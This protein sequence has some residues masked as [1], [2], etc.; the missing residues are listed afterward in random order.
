MIANYLGILKQRNCNKTDGKKTIKQN[1]ADRKSI[2]P[3]NYGAFAGLY[4]PR[5]RYELIKKNTDENDCLGKGN[6]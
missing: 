5:P 4:I 1:H 6:V 2:Q 3:G